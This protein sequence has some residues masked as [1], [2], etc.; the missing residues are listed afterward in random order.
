MTSKE[1]KVMSDRPDNSNTV[2]APRIHHSGASLVDGC[3]NSS[4]DVRCG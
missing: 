2:F 1:S 4:N 3:L